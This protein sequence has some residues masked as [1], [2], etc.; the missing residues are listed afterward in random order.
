ITSVKADSDREALLTDA[1]EKLGEIRNIMASG[2][3]KELDSAGARELYSKQYSPGL[4]EYVE[5]AS[6]YY[7]LKAGGD[8]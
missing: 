3:L 7:Y 5:A 8:M 2:L 6:M 1:A 4:Q